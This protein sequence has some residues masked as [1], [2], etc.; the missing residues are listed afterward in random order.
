[1]ELTKKQII[2]PKFLLPKEEKSRLEIF[3]RKEKFIEQYLSVDNILKHTQEIDN[4]KEFLFDEKQLY[5]FNNLPRR[6]LFS[7]ENQEEVKKFKI[8]KIE[9]IIEC[10]KSNND[11]ISQKLLRKFE[12][13]GC[14]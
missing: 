1:M 4:I 13:N 2:C 12:E 5:L 8:L 10:L 6:S 14:F 7:Y 9:D 11:E 3:E